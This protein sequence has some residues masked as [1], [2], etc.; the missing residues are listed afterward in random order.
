M[1]KLLLIPALLL[2]AR[3]ALAQDM[4][5][6]AKWTGYQ[7][8]HYKIVGEFSGETILVQ[9]TGKTALDKVMAR[10]TDRVEVEFD[11]DQQDFNLVGKPVIRNFPT[12]VVSVNLVFES[13]HLNKVFRSTCPEPKLSGALELVTGLSVKADDSM[14]M[15]GFVN[16]E[17][18]RDQPGGSYA[19]VFPADDARANEQNAACGQF[20]ET[21][22]PMSATSTMLL[23]A[24]P[25]MYLAMPLPAT[26]EGGMKLSADKKSI[27]LPPGKPGASNAG[28][29]WTVTPTGVK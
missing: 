19:S 12:K 22:K 15:S 28:W 4:E 10:V 21:A 27:I 8:V 11:W 17:V 3:P 13:M 20:W 18:R 9:G 14:R 7:I 16:L 26:G 2:F 23:H 5:A 1:K 6:M 24:V 25:G 29:T